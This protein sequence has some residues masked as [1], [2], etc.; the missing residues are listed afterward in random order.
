MVKF[1]FGINNS[2]HLQNNV[3]LMLKVQKQNCCLN[4]CIIGEFGWLFDLIYESDPWSQ[5]QG[6]K[7]TSPK[8]W[9][10]KHEKFQKGCRHMLVEIT[11]KKCEPSAFPV[12]L[13]ASEE[14]GSGNTAVAAAEENNCLLLMEENKNLRKQKLELQ[15]QIS[16][17]KALEMKLLD[18][19]A[20]NMEDHQN[21]V[22]CWWNKWELFLVF[23]V[24][25]FV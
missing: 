8:Q 16:Q 9:E 14:S 1:G 24:R 25:V 3:C 18:C 23:L 7:K 20:Q 12:Y 4:P 22:R 11:R 19:L 2:M 21:K 5:K 15:M 6:F 10:F 13:K 17:F